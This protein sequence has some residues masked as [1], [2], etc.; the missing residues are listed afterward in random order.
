M[1]NHALWSWEMAW[2]VWKLTGVADFTGNLGTGMWWSAF[3]Q[4][5]K[6]WVWRELRAVRE[7]HVLGVEGEGCWSL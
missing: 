1:A 2:G 3:G 7:C 5:Q 6:S 4:N